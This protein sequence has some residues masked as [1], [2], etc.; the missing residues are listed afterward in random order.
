MKKGRLVMDSNIRDLGLTT[1]A[2]LL[3]MGTRLKDLSKYK[4]NLG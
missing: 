3:T 1:P 2:H 4:V